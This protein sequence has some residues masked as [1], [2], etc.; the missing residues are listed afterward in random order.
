MARLTALSLVQ[1][2]DALGPLGLQ[3]QR[4]EPLDAGSVNSNF[5][6]WDRE[7]RVYFLRLY[8]EQ[9]VEGARAELDLL[10]ELSAAQVPVA[11]ALTLRGE[12]WLGQAQGR[13]LAIFPW[14]D[15]EMRCQ[16]S[17]TEVTCQ[18]LGAALAQVHSAPVTSLP[19]GRF[20]LSDLQRRLE[21]VQA[22]S[23][24][25]RP[26]A[27]RVKHLLHD[28]TARRDP[29]LPR[30]LTHGDLFR[31][32]VLWQQDRIAV[33][34]DFESAS[35]GPFVYD[36]AVCL[37]AWA[38]DSAFEPA[39]LRA[40]LEGY[41]AVRKLSLAEREALSTEASF[42]AL[43]FATTRMTDYSLRAKPGEPPL[44]DYQRFLARFEAIEAGVLDSSF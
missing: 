33:L 6:L 28:V 26:D 25:L 20:K 8:E 4:L 9:G 5:R 7:G 11:P 13:P 24:T 19:Q 18:R 38:F 30:G 23:P 12:P 32:N 1:A 3:T 42:A 37:L 34:L 15:G 17:V 16:R 10:R 41:Q 2:T 27:A 43:R 35:E 36:L 14:F 31:D 29:Q 39:L 22:E 44:R 40:M 21:R